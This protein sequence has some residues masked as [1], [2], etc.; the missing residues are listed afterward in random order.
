MTRIKAF[1][2]NVTETILDFIGYVL[3]ILI[4]ATCMILTGLLV[5]GFALLPFVLLFFLIKFMSV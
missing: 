2:C 3:S 4:S 1:L 5:L